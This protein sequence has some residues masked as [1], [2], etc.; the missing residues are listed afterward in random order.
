MHG[1]TMK[2]TA[3]F[4][5][6]VTLKASVKLDIFALRNLKVSLLRV[7]TVAPTSSIGASVKLVPQIALH[8]KIRAQ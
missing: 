3:S 2:H 5:I 8:K 6:T 4:K 7:A 1:T